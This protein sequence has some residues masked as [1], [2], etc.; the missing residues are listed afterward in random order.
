MYKFDSIITILQEYLIWFTFL[1]T[2]IKEN[3]SPEMKNIVDTVGSF[4]LY[5]PYSLS[6][7]L[8]K[9]ATHNRRQYEWYSSDQES[10]E[11][12]RIKM[13][14]STSQYSRNLV[15]WIN[16]KIEY[17]YSPLSSE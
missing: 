11:S 10:L 5:A 13:G 15:K 4:K 17:T 14:P 16:G 8:C 12:K 1:Q 9:T 7:K 3:L 6:A 2:L